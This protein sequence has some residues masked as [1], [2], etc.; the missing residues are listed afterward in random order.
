MPVYDCVYRAV[1]PYLNWSRLSRMGIACLTSDSRSSIS[2]GNLPPVPSPDRNI[3]LRPEVIHLLLKPFHICF[4]NSDFNP[5][6]CAAFGGRVTLI[7]T[8]EDGVHGNVLLMHSASPKSH[9]SS[10]PLG[11]TPLQATLAPEVSCAPF[12]TRCK[13][14]SKPQVVGL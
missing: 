5:L 6:F 14:S 3:P 12:I 7:R 13:P 9:P 8:P 2:S 1:G 10:L 11:G 4:D